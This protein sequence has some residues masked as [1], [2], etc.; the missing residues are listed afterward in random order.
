MIIGTRSLVR[1]F[2]KNLVILLNDS[3]LMTSAP[4][5]MMNTGTAHRIK[6]SII[7]PIIQ[8]GLSTGLMR[9]TPAMQWM[10]ITAMMAAIR[11]MS[12]SNLLT[13]SIFFI[14]PIV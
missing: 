12:R 9:T 5:I 8:E 6:L 7:L 2:L 3:G 13:L 11:S 1:R 10:T 4:L 14:Q